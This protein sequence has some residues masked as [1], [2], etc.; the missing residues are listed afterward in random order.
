MRRAAERLR[1]TDSLYVAEV[2][3]TLG[4]LLALAG[5]ADGARAAIAP[6]RGRY[7]AR[8]RPAIRARVALIGLAVDG[9][10]GAALAAFVPEL[11]AEHGASPVWALVDRLRAARG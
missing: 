1:A 11:R 5:D 6:W 9:A 8:L 7:A 4:V 2:E 10:D 3:S